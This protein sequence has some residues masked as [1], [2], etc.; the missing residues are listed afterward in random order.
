MRKRS[1]VKED[2]PKLEDLMFKNK[3][4]FKRS[5]N[6]KYLERKRKNRG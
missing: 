6:I 3:G 1:K 2:Y 5:K 4:A